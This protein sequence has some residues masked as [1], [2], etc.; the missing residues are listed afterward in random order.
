MGCMNVQSVLERIQPQHCVVVFFFFN[1]W[2]CLVLQISKKTI[3]LKKFANGKYSDMHATSDI[4]VF[5]IFERQL[6]DLALLAHLYPYRP[7]HFPLSALPLSQSVSL[8][9]CLPLCLFLTHPP[10]KEAYFQTHLSVRL[11]EGSQR[12]PLGH[13]AVPLNLI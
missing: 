6:G 7:I 8:H 9:R 2:S 10:S 12:H 11:Q 5:L 13:R 3:P 1:L 4:G